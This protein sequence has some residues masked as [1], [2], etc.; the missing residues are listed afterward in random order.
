MIFPKSYTNLSGLKDYYKSTK[1]RLIFYSFYGTRGKFVIRYVS[2]M[3]MSTLSH[4]KT[5]ELTGSSKP[6]VKEPHLHMNR[7]LSEVGMKSK[8]SERRGSIESY[9]SLSL[10]REGKVIKIIQN[11]LSSITSSRFL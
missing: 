3:V 7:A 9:T 1:S 11:E 8:G 5:R 2:V 10:T 4:S 6:N